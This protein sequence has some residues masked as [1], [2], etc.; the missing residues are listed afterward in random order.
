[1]CWSSPKPPDIPAPPPPPAAP[2]QLTSDEVASEAEE[3]KRRARAV[4]GPRATMISGAQGLVQPA[5]TAQKSLI[6]GTS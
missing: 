3:V 5:A 4:Q 6:G 2:P 1:M